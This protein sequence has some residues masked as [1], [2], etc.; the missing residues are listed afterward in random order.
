MIAAAM[1]EDE[2]SALENLLAEHALPNDGMSLEMLDGFF[3]ALVVGPDLVM[4]NEYLPHVWGADHAWD[5]LEQSQQGIELVM[6]LWNHIVWRVNQPLPE[7]DDAEQDLRLLPV[8]GLPEPPEGEFDDATDPFASIPDDFPFGATW[9]GSFLHG[10]SLR[11]DEWAAWMA[12]HEELE[13][14]LALLLD[15]AVVDAQHA[16]ELG[17]P[18]DAV[19]DFRQRLEAVMEIPDMLQCMYLQRQQ[20]HHTQPIRRAAQPGRNDACPCGSGR[21]YKKCCGDAGRLH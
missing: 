5:T 12:Q 3:S 8:M 2:M 18:A 9:A 14:D 10:M 15:L 19:I 7:E 13:E 11:A 1:T 4:P 20:D 21:K 16:Q 6:Q 17:R